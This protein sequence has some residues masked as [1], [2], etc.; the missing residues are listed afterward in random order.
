MRKIIFASITIAIL[1]LIGAFAIVSAQD[2]TPSTSDTGT[3]PERDSVSLAIYNQGTA[4]VQDRRTFTFE[5]GVNL[6][7]FTDVAA[8]I[9]P[10]SVSFT[11]LTDREGT[12]VLEQNYVYDLVGTSALLA[13]YVDETIRVSTIDGTIYEGQLLSGRS[14]VILRTADGGVVVVSP[15]DI[16]DIR[17]PELPSGLIT[18]PTLRWLINSQNGGEQQ[19]ELTYLTGG[20]NWT[21]DYNVL[22]ATGNSSLDL[23]GWVT[24]NNNSGTAYQDAQVKLV[25]GDVN[26]VQPD[27]IANRAIEFE[28]QADFAGAPAVEQREFFEYQLYEIG[29]QVTIGNNE[30]KQV[31]FVN[32][33]NVPATTFFVYDGSPQFYG[34]GGFY[35]DQFYGMTGISDVQNFLEFTTAEENG[36][37]A[38]LPAGRIRVYQEDVDGAALLIG[39]NRIDHTPEGE[40]VQIYL[41]NAFDLVGERTQIGF[42]LIGDR[43]VDETFEIRLRNRKDEETVQIRIPE[44]LTRGANWEILNASHPYEALNAFAIEFRV[45]VPAGE[46][47]IVTYTVRYTRPR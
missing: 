47:V 29:R 19:V 22:L 21:A 8:S 33:T 38:D 10:T 4:L 24:I 32:G 7:N 2:D 30:T 39:E 5:T 36:L 37:G 28:M 31:E 12:V 27:A 14:E 45:D 13:R 20:I 43:V 17:F 44:R 6:I 16:R 3:A 9:D 18:R 34:Y 26:R 35:F 15:D 11:S 1:L 25:A 46:E 40:N 42:Q 23:N 41:G